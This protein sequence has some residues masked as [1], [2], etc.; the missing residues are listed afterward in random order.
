MPD[1]EITL[2]NTALGGGNAQPADDAAPQTP[3]VTPGDAQNLEN[4]SNGASQQSN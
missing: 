4:L 1:M 2:Q 3:Q